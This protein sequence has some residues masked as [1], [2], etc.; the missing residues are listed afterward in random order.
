MSL[1]D[2]AKLTIEDIESQIGD[3]EV[4]YGVFKLNNPNKCIWITIS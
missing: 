3:Y 4:L 1:I 2:M